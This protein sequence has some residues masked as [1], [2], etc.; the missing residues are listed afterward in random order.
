MMWPNYH[1]SHDH[2]QIAPQI[3]CIVCIM[4]FYNLGYFIE[5]LPGRDGAGWETTLHVVAAIL[6]TPRDSR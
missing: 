4:W 3:I 5:K 1:A 2:S 6:R